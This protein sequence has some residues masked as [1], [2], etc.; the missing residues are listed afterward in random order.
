MDITG[1]RYGRLIVMGDAPYAFTKKGLMIRRVV[2][3]C[4]CW[5]TKNI[6]I[7]NLRS[8][9][10]VS[11]WCYHIELTKKR[12]IRVHGTHLLSW[13]KIHMKWV[14]LKRRCNYKNHPQYKDWWWKWITYDP[15]REK[16]E[17]FYEDMR[18]SY[19]KHVAEHWEKQTTLDR[20][21]GNWNYSKENCR[22]ATY[23][24]QNSN[25]KNSFERKHWIK[26]C[27]LASQFWYS[28]PRIRDILRMNNHDI[29]KTME[30]LSNRK[31]YDRFLSE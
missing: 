18:D 13:T 12:A 29:V 14:G 16:F 11:C 2:C 19:T 10:I 30:V 28:E 7:G 9:S 26:L 24:Q 21:D 4:D 1:E 22:W 20:V 3:K 23:I 17:W 8:G 5:V 6:R 31:R 27:D 15:K 25:R